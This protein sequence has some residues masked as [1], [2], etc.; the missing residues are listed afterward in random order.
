VSQN[1]VAG[2][3]GQW[4][5]RPFGYPNETPFPDSTDCRYFILDTGNG[6]VVT[7]LSPATWRS[8]LKEY[9][10]PPS[11]QITAPVLPL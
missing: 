10:V 1:I 7:A 9:G 3:V 6:R 11:L 5:P 8:Q 2:C 4:P